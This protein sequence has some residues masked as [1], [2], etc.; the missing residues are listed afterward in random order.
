MKLKLYDEFNCWQDGG[1]IWLYSDPHFNDPESKLMNPNW[2]EA[3]EIVKNINAKVGKNDTL[4]ILGDIGDESY[5]RKL[6]GA[7]KIL[8][9]G[10]HDK[11]SSNYERKEDWI[12]LTK[13]EA[14]QFR[15]DRKAF[16]EEQRKDP[17]FREIFTVDNAPLIC[18]ICESEFVKHVDNRMFDCVYD[19]PLFISSKILLSHEPI[20]LPY[21]INIHGHVHGAETRSIYWTD[22]SAMVNI[23]SDV[24]DFEP[25]RLDEIVKKFKV[26]TIH[27]LIIEKARTRKT[28]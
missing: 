7:Y 15:N 1:V 6:K 17:D 27:E 12:P 26:K 28:V 20:Q 2:P 23:C 16:I 5:V 25:I 3:D 4:I 22:N 8:I 21:G 19:G 9:K 18:E 11:G 14:E 24:V 13:E 10:N